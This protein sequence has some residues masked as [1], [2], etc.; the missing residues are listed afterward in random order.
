MGALVQQRWLERVRVDHGHG[1]ADRSRHVFDALLAL[2][3]PAE[4]IQ[5]PPAQHT[6]LLQLVIAQLVIVQLLQ[7][8]IVRLL[9]LVI[10]QLLQLVIVQL[11]QLVI[12][13][14]L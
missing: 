3:A 1:S 11:L 14:L 12:V 6:R 13:Q 8:V 4:L 5:G 7:L 2:Q 9:Q 10:V